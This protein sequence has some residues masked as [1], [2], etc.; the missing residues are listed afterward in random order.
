MTHWFKHR[1]SNPKLIAAARVVIAI[2]FFLP[3]TSNNTI[4]HIVPEKYSSRYDW[5]EYK[6]RADQETQQKWPP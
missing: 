1:N 5:L 2:A 3:I 4:I 6:G